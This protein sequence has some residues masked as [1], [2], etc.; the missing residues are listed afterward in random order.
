M[1]CSSSHRNTTSDDV[2]K[3]F[4]VRFGPG[5]I[6]GR[7]TACQSIT[8][9]RKRREMYV[10]P[11]AEVR[12]CNHFCSERAINITYCER[13]RE[14][15][16]ECVCVCVALS[17]QHAMRMRNII[18]VACPT[19]PYFSTLSHK[20]HDFRKKCYLT[21]MCILIFSTTWSETFLILR[22]N[23]RD[24]ITNVYMVFM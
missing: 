1:P 17:I 5:Y 11:K 4:H 8:S 19:P 14:R 7:A 16:R 23:G 13:E 2:R 15:E 10:Q 24:M 6:V 3:A 12:S 18:I 22:R 20:R 21:K 9:L